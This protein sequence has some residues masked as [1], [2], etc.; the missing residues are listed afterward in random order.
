M[1]SFLSSCPNA[2]RPLHNAIGRNR[3]PPAHLTHDRRE[4]P[5]HHTQQLMSCLGPLGIVPGSLFFTNYE[6][7]PTLLLSAPGS[8]QV[9]R[10]RVTTC[11]WKVAS[12]Q[13]HVVHPSARVQP[14]TATRVCDC[15][16]EFLSAHMPMPPTDCIAMWA[17]V[18]GIRLVLC[19]RR[20][21]VAA[22]DEHTAV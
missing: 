19:S 16:L 2:P 12:L 6:F 18:T 13:T 7:S 17:C 1:L 22:S 15:C 4:G 9:P 21:G 14:G 10:E 3:S 5:T 11:R 8:T 20:R